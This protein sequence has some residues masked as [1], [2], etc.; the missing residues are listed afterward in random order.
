VAT[1]TSRRRSRAAHGYR[2]LLVPLDAS[3]ESV[4]AFE[5]ACRL[6]ADDHASVTAIVVLRIPALIPLDSH[7]RDAEESARALLERAGAT[8]DAYGVRA[9]PKLVRARDGATPILEQAALDGCEL[10]VIGAAATST[11]LHIVNGATCR[12][13]IVSDRREDSRASRGLE[14][15]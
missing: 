13:M 15:V 7:L 10:I 4:E 1:T 9:I 14:F 8:A 12:V 6:A 5:I 11:V 3:H 2:R